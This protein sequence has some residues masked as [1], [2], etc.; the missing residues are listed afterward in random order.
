[1]LRV[2]ERLAVISNNGPLVALWTLDLLS[3]LRDLYTEVLIP[4][5]VKNEFLAT[6][7]IAREQALKNAPWITTVTLITP[8]GE[9]ARLGI[10]RG[11]AAVFAL[12][13]ERGTRLVILDDKEARRYAKR[14]GLPLTGTVGILLE[15][16]K[17]GLIDA[18]KPLL[19][20]LLENGVRLGASLV[21]DAL[22]EAGEMD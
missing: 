11:E 12:A 15:A 13:E 14:I 6:G 19:N 18:I 20:V 3:L 22:Q 7:E 5:E 21:N 10:H 1:M 9:L 17:S 2:P 4:E 16:K 8:L